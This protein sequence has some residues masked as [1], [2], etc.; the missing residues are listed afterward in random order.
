MPRLRSSKQSKPRGRV[1]LRELGRADVTAR[2]NRWLRQSEV[3]RW[4]RTKPSTLAGLRRYVLAQRRNPHVMFWGI[5]AGGRHV[6]NIKAEHQHGVEGHV[7][8]LGL[9]IGEGRGKG[10]GTAAIRQA[11]AWCFRRWKVK[12]VEAGLHPRNWGSARAF[13]KAGYAILWPERVWAVKSTPC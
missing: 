3:C 6:G 8:V 10:Y 12:R 9:L 5:F 2:Y 1:A 13:E 11:S 7:A 4:I